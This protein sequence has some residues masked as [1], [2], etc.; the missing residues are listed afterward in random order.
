MMYNLLFVLLLGVGGALASPTCS[1]EEAAKCTDGK[2]PAWAFDYGYWPSTKYE[3]DEICHKAI[4][5]LD[6]EIDFA[7]RCPKSLIGLHLRPLKKFKQLF[8]K[9]CDDSSRL[10]TD[11]LRRVSC[12]NHK[13]SIVRDVCHDDA[14][15][16]K[17]GF[18]CSDAVH[19]TEKCFYGVIRDNCSKPHAELFR[20]VF[21]PYTAMSVLQC[22]YAT[23]NKA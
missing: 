22:E 12:I 18:K 9:I 10:R 20:T 19:K 3:L 11:Y 21:Q 5:E 13:M 6:C 2:R 17:P 14:D 1:E 8:T 7:E 16:T 4:P 23:N 15:V